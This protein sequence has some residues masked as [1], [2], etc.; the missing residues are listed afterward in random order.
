M[1][2]TAA[3]FSRAR[4][5]ALYFHHYSESL[6]VMQT[7]CRGQRAARKKGSPGSLAGFGALLQAKVR[8]GLWS[9]HNPGGDNP[10]L[11]GA[12]ASRPVLCGGRT[13]ASQRGGVKPAP[14]LT[15]TRDHFTFSLLI[16][17]TASLSGSQSITH[18]M[19]RSQKFQSCPPLAWR[20]VTGKPWASSRSR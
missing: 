1:A 17:R 14:P 7:S 12:C 3:A 10:L 20:Q 18:S 2:C 4:A 19:A 16:P 11:Q 9:R 15:R 6:R 8:S 13:R 5:Y